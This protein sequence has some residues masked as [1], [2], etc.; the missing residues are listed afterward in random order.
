MHIAYG[1]HVEV[2]GGQDLVPLAA[3]PVEIRANDFVDV[4]YG[5]LVAIAETP[6]LPK[7]EI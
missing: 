2:A 7:G 3:T 4:S 6:Q 1:D 5:N